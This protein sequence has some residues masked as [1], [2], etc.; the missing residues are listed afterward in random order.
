MDPKPTTPPLPFDTTLGRPIDA[1][2]AAAPAG[3]DATDP[4]ASAPPPAPE[5][6]EL[7]V[8]VVRSAKRRK[9]VQASVVEGR[10]RI[11]LPARMTKSE[12]AHWVTEM[13]RRFRRRSR[14]DRI[15]LSARARR[16]A[17]NL[18][19]SRPTAIHWV[20]NQRQRWGS[21]TPSTGEIRVSTRIAGY[22]SWVIDYVIV[23][24]LAHLDVADHSPAFHAIV[25]RFPLAERARGY[26]IA[27]G[28][29]PES[30]L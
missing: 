15:N 10:L 8:E 19:L 6:D 24:E 5:A 13:Q 11:L 4:S 1:G 26:L 29:D 16:L 2:D 20:D 9:T 22:P 23:H 18:G 12:E 17:A 28:V 30:E 25:D 27:K 14:A 3:A 7:E 21:C